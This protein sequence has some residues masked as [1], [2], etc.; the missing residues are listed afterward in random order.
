[1]VRSYVHRAVF[2]GESSAYID[3][4]VRVAC[5]HCLLSIELDERH[6]SMRREMT[7]LC[8]GERDDHA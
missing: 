1:M 6:G 5:S 7:D 4:T 3:S 2:S 8:E